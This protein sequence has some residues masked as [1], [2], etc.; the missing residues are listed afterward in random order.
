MGFARKAPVQALYRV[1]E[2][3]VVIIGV[4]TL[5]VSVGVTAIGAV[6][7]RFGHNRG[8]G[9]G[10]A[11]STPRCPE[12]RDGRQPSAHEGAFKSHAGFLKPEAA[13]IAVNKHAV[14]VIQAAFNVKNKIKP[15]HGGIIGHERACGGAVSDGVGHIVNKLVNN[16]MPDHIAL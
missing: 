10:A 16:L 5:V 6:S 15:A 4:F 11:R 14:A 13:G 3:V 2:P 7:C 9:K 12:D 8:L 1:D